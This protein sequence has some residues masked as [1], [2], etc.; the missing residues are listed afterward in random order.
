MEG[1]VTLIV[2]SERV[3][4]VL[5][6]RLPGSGGRTIFTLP[7]ARKLLV[8]EGDITNIHVAAIVNATN[9]GLHLGAGVSGAI[10]RRANPSLRVELHRL[11]GS[12]R[13]G[14][15]EVVLTGAHGLPNVR[16]ILHANAVSGDPEVVESATVGSLELASSNGLES[17][18]LPLL[19]AGTGGLA[20][21][22][23]ARRMVQGIVR[24]AAVDFGPTELVMLVA[25][26][27]AAWKEARDA[28]AEQLRPS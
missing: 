5:R 15:G 27:D 7:G 19:G 2:G 9:G 12:A 13:I 14:R 8:V 21:A 23:A 4:Q 26:G 22:V 6:S 18:A 16:A 1:H 25:W 11:A 10:R 3:A 20:V 17:V 24:W 28:A